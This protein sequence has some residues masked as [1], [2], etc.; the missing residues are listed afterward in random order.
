MHRSHNSS[1]STIN[2]CTA[3][4]N[5][6]LSVCILALVIRHEEAMR[7]IILSYVFCQAVQ[8]SAHYDKQEINSGPV[9][10][11][12]C[13]SSFPLKACM[14]DVKCSKLRDIVINYG[15]VL[16]DFILT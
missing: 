11:L 8:Y 13:A 6:W 16:T 15:S 7:H 10:E 2:I 3:V 4:R 9:I 5:G 14:K 12:K 1:C